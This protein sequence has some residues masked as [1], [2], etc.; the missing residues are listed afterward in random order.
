MHSDEVRDFVDERLNE[1]RK[2]ATTRTRIGNT[3]MYGYPSLQIRWEQDDD[4]LGWSGVC[5]IWT[6]GN[7]KVNCQR[8]HTVTVRQTIPLGGISVIFDGCAGGSWA[9]QTFEGHALTE[10][11]LE[12][13][14]CWA[15]LALEDKHRRAPAF[16]HWKENED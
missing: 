5:T 9:Y 12:W 3:P 13:A 7:T 4:G 10:R 8:E 11:D 6:D 2:R 15:L 1:Q 14:A 16:C